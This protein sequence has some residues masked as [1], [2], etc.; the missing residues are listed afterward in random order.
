MGLSCAPCGAAIPAEAVDRARS[1]ARCAYCGSVAD[2]ARRRGPAGEEFPFV[3]RAEVPLP[4]GFSVERRG[5]GLEIVRSWRSWKYVPIGIFALFWNLVMLFMVGVSGGAGC[6]FGGAHILVGVA[7][8]YWA[9]AGLLNR[10]EVRVEPGSVEVRHRPLPWP[11][12]LRV[13]TGG[14]VQVY[15]A[16]RVRRTSDP[17][18]RTYE[19][20]GIRRPGGKVVLLR[21]LDDLD[22]ALFVEQRIEAHLG[23]ADRPVGGEVPR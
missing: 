19:V 3:E 6:L 8:G 1:L 4:P 22:Q 10:T 15:C 16:E 21:H 9:L 20:A 17:E 2:L 12:N 13:E 18:R 5:E 7:M 14:L 23:L 11:G